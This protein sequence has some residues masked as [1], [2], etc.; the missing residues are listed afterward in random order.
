[1]R[2]KNKP[3]HLS[4]INY[5]NKAIVFT[6]HLHIDMIFL[7]LHFLSIIHFLYYEHIWFYQLSHQRMNETQCILGSTI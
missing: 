7:I 6:F 5:C 3:Q 4:F 1:M 2:N